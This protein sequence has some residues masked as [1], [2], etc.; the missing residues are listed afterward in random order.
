[1]NTVAA[2][3]II[4]ALYEGLRRDPSGTTV[5]VRAQRPLDSIDGYVVGGSGVRTL[6]LPA[7]RDPLSDLVFDEATCWGSLTHWALELP[8]GTHYVGAWLEKQTYY[9]DAVDV[10]TDLELAW[11]TAVERGE[12]AIYDGFKQTSRSVREPS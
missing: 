3:G 10:F 12:M 2:V 4:G 11:N 5:S 1:M 6:E 9:F 7:A 8:I